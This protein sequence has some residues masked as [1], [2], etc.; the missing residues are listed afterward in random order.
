MGVNHNV[1]VMQ[2]NPPSGDVPVKPPTSPFPAAPSRTSCCG[3]GQLLRVLTPLCQQSALTLSASSV[4][5][6]PTAPGPPS[7]WRAAALPWGPTGRVMQTVRFCAGLHDSLPRGHVLNIPQRDVFF[8]SGESVHLLPLFLCFFWFSCLAPPLL[9]DSRQRE[10]LIAGA[11]KLSLKRVLLS[12]KSPQGF[13][14]PLALQGQGPILPETGMP[15]WLHA[16]TGLGACGNCR[17]FAL[18]VHFHTSAVCVCWVSWGLGLA[19]ALGTGRC[20][21]VP[22]L[23]WHSV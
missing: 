18:G 8:P 23:A 9:P 5:R 7:P 6:P 12:P 21:S 3:T 19:G 10:H 11:A 13:A 15:G 22:V 2:H 1:L 20:G 14:W 4:N 16:L 17:G